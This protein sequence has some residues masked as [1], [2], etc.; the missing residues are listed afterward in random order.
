MNFR[1]GILRKHR[2]K[3]MFCEKDT[4]FLRSHYLRFVQCS[5]VMVESSVEIS[6]NFVAFSK[7]M[8]FNIKLPIYFEISK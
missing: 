1:L 5:V 7:Y 4:T 8:N 3:L 2:D 6:Q